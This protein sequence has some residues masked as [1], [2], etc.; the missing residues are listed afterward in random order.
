MKHIPLFEE[1]IAIESFQP[2]NEVAEIYDIKHNDKI[3]K[4][5][6]VVAKHGTPDV[7]SVKRHP[8]H[9]GSG[10]QVETRIDSLWGDY[11]L[12]REY[13]VTVKLTNPCPYVIMDADKGIGH[14]TA[15]F[16]K[17]GDYNEF[18]Y[19]NTVEG[20]PDEEDNLSIFIVD[21]QKSYVSMRLINTIKTD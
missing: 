3:K 10:E 14:D 17:Y 16:T 21:F 1:Y 12:F 4:G 13:E 2:L 20:Y 6:T 7:L 15:D 5:M 19:H 8:I 18:I 9:L 11:P